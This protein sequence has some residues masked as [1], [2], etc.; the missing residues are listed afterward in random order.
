METQGSTPTEFTLF[1]KLPMEL[2]LRI[3][4][5]AIP[6]QRIIRIKYRM[7]FGNLLDKNMP[8]I[9]GVSREARSVAVK[10]Y[11]GYTVLS[12]KAD[13][14]RFYF[15]PDRDI[16]CFASSYSMH[17][18]IYRR[19]E[20]N[21]IRKEI[22]HIILAAETE[23]YWPVAISFASAFKSLESF[24]CLLQDYHTSKESELD[25]LR[26]TIQEHFRQANAEGSSIKNIP[27]IVFRHWDDPQSWFNKYT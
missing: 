10:Y 14:Q 21:F 4:E 7:L 8:A 15:N 25:E 12:L 5:L 20:S 16:L 22:R 18:F 11:S 13:K 23:I 9:I 19:R 24:T 1:G 27:T 26:A 17:G 6:D 2:R 3:W